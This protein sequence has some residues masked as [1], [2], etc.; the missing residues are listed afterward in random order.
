MVA[1][2][3]RA[4]LPMLFVVRSSRDSV[5]CFSA[6]Q[7]L[8]ASLDA[9]GAMC[10]RSPTSAAVLAYA[11]H[12]MSFENK[13]ADAGRLPPGAASMQMRRTPFPEPATD[14]AFPTP[15]AARLAISVQLS[16]PLGS[17]PEPDRAYPYHRP[18]SGR[19]R[20]HFVRSILQPAGCSVGRVFRLRIEGDERVGGGSMD[21]VDHRFEQL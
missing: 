17:L 12:S 11:T 16:R 2:V 19:A 18:R 21:G 10:S 5:L 4:D 3:G 7:G 20:G 14:A 15:L 6:A 1:P 8:A 13:A 9:M